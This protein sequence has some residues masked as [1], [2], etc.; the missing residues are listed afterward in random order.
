M[1]SQQLFL[2]EASFLMSHDSATGYIQPANIGG[3]GSSSSSGGGSSSSHSLASSLTWQY[4]KNQ[5]GSVYQQLDDGARALDLRPKLLTNGTIIFQHGDINIGVT[6]E[7]VLADAVRWCTDNHQ[8]HHSEEQDDTNSG[9]L[10]LLLP[11]NFAYQKSQSSGFT[12]DDD[13]Y[14]NNHNGV[15]S[16]VSIMESIYAQYNIPYVHCSDVYGMTVAEVM[17]LAALPTGGYMIAMDGQDYYGTPC[18]KPN[19][20]EEEL[21]PCY[22][23]SLSCTHRTSYLPSK[24]KSY[25]LQSTNNDVTDDKHTLGPPANLYQ[26][27]LNEIQALWQVTSASAM[28]GMSRMSSILEDN[29]R[30]RLNEVL[31]SMIHQNEFQ[32][33]SVLAVDNVA[34]H[35]NAIL[36]VLRTACGQSN[37]EECGSALA[38]PR[39][40]YFQFSNLGQYMLVATYVLVVLGIGVSV[41]LAIRKRDE[42]LHP[43][44]LWTAFYRLYKTFQESMLS[45]NASADKTEEFLPQPV[46]SASLRPYQKNGL[47]S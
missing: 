38:A 2:S 46:D 16:I 44:L 8:Q 37:L 20:V 17:E 45:T 33:I 39:L 6:L 41:G 12:D 27:P 10:I 26:Y 28:I 31:V 24:L 36:S 42:K 18:A 11:S 9:E 15:A 13:S 40:T 14:G 7:Q 21:V 5:I 22:I 19:W 32:A 4:S 43:I 3:S 29:R 30:S 34:L 35:G 47:P 23:K 25:I 1:T